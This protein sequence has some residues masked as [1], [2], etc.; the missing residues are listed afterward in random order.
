[1]KEGVLT[2]SPDYSDRDPRLFGALE[3]TRRPVYDLIENESEFQTHEVQ[4]EGRSNINVE[5]SLFG[6]ALSDLFGI[7]AEIKD[8]RNN[9][10]V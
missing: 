8:R 9:N 4:P 6:K 3:S 1:L 10:P 7:L 5:Y 2:I